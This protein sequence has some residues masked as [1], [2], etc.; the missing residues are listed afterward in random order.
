M[1]RLTAILLVGAILTSTVVPTRAVT[2]TTNDST[3]GLPVNPATLTAPTVL[4][5]KMA[6]NSTELA[7]YQQKAEQ[8]QALAKYEAAGGTGKTVALTVVVTVLVIAGVAALALVHDGTGSWNG[9]LFPSNV[10]L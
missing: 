6:L 5:Q 8:S 3:F 2:G 10:V 7:K 4:S 1:N 9:P